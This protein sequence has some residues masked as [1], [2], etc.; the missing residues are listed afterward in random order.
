MR[1][2]ECGNFLHF[3]FIDDLHGSAIYRCQ[4][5]PVEVRVAYDS[6]EVITHSLDHTD[7]Y[8][9]HD[10]TSLVRV[11]PVGI[12]QRKAPTVWTTKLKEVVSHAMRTV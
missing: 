3:S 8:Y 1:C 4:S 5:A 12:H 2:P 7:H 6:K 9:R 11:M 10:G